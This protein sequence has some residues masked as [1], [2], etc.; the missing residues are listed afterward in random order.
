MITVIGDWAV[1]L[2]VDDDGHLNVDINHGDGTKVVQIEEDLTANDTEWADR[3][4]T[5]GIELAYL[6]STGVPMVFACPRCGIIGAEGD[7]CPK[8]CQLPM[9][10]MTRNKAKQIAT[11]HLDFLIDCMH[12]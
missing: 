5:E 9:E 10:K 4:T 3:F 8:Y 11:D 7:K 1:S 12:Y 6:E 2:V